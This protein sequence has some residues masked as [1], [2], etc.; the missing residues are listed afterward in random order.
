MT[1]QATLFGEKVDVG[2]IEAAPSVRLRPYQQNAC[3]AAE[4]EFEKDG[5]QSTLIVLPTGTGKSVVFSEMLRR[6]LERHEA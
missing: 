5:I 1:K 4:A 2:A 3:D 6:H